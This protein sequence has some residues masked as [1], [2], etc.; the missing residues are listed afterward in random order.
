MAL[1]APPLARAQA[2]LTGARAVTIHVGSHT[3]F[4]DEAA[5]LGAA[6]TGPSPYET[7]LASLGACTAMTLRMYAERK[8]WSIGTVHVDLEFVRDGDAERID[9][10]IR[11]AAALSPA[12]VER[13]AEIAE[14]T[15]VTRTLARSLTIPTRL[16]HG[17]GG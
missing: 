12:Q 2:T 17:T 13:L 11:I 16:V 3:L 9:R 15:P 7:L 6:A 8:Q 10:T 4:V 14:K 1:Y 5:G